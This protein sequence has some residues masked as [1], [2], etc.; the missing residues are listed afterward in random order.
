M[1]PATQVNG[2]LVGGRGH[3]VNGHAVDLA[4]KGVVLA[5]DVDPAADCPQ[6]KTAQDEQDESHVGVSRFGVLVNGSERPVGIIVASCKRRA[7][8]K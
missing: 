6:Q 2:L 5:V 3:A 8:R 4:G 1:A 7:N